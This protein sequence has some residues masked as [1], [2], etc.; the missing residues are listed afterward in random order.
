MS[1][2]HDDATSAVD[3]EIVLLP[4]AE[5]FGLTDLLLWCVPLGGCLAAVLA[6]GWGRQHTDHAVLFGSL[7]MWGIILGL[8]AAFMLVMAI[9]FAI[10]SL[11]D[12]RRGETGPVAQGMRVSVTREAIRIQ[13]RDGS[14]SEVVRG[15]APT[16]LRFEGNTLVVDEQ[17]VDARG[18]DHHALSAAVETQGWQQA[19]S[20]EP[21]D[22]VADEG[23]PTSWVQPT[24]SP[25]PAAARPDRYSRYRDVLASSLPTIVIRSRRHW[26]PRPVHWSGVLA[27]VGLII[28]VVGDLLYGPS[29]PGRPEPFALDFMLPI[30][31][32]LGLASMWSYGYPYGRGLKD[33]SGHTITISTDAVEVERG[34]GRTY[35]FRSSHH[36]RLRSDGLLTQAGGGIRLENLDTPRFVREAERRGWRIRLS[37]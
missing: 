5:T 14:A 26:F 6:G 16:T 34:D 3:D 37:S 19:L 30:P 22:L 11:R 2:D 27:L 33:A 20:A 24:S 35:A 8:G 4:G 23:V 9:G 25:E 29:A 1:D 17:R 28:L 13:R 7:T 10:A 32:L 36:L 31:L 15:V 18:I 12:R 21:A